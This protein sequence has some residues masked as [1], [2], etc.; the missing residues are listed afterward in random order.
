MGEAP[1]GVLVSAH[2]RVVL[3]GPMDRR[4]W[5]PHGFR[6]FRP[7]DGRQEWPYD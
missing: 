7:V 4:R 2:W 6:D 1:R 3:W 5:A